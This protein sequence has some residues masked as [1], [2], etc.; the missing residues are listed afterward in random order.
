MGFFRGALDFR[1]LGWI[2]VDYVGGYFFCGRGGL[3]GILR[4]GFF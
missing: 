4:V 1:A 3:V 2:V